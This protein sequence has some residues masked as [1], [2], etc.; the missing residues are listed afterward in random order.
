[1]V[2]GATAKVDVLRREK[3]DFG[4]L[5]PESSRLLEREFRTERA[6]GR[7]TAEPSEEESRRLRKIW[8]TTFDT[9]VRMLCRSE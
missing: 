5:R 9:L 3:K 1:M 8:L 6:T 4:R 7:V 2:L